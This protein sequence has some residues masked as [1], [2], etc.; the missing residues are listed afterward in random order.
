M[1]L[2]SYQNSR[3][4]VDDILGNNSTLPLQHIDVRPLKQILIVYPG[5]ARVLR[6]LL[7]KPERTFG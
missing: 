4:C 2:N 1:V 7:R 5:K 3:Y 6:T